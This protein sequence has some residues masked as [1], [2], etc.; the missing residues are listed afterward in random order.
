MIEDGDESRSTARRLHGARLSLV[1]SLL[2]LAG[3][4]VPPAAQTP[5]VQALCGANVFTVRLAGFASPEIEL[6]R[7]GFIEMRCYGTRRS[8]AADRAYEIVYET[9]ASH[10]EFLEGL[11]RLLDELALRA[12]IV[13]EGELRFRIV[14]Q[15]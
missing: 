14:R 10:E 9:N 6:M 15:P 2:M 8:G 5:P 13:A 1:A 7:R 12:M 3:T 4:S 11:R